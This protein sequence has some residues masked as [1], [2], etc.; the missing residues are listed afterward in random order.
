MH[1]LI[2]FLITDCNA[3]HS[4]PQKELFQEL[5]NRNI[6]KLYD[7]YQFRGANFRCDYWNASDYAQYI[8]GFLNRWNTV[9][10]KPVVLFYSKTTDSLRMWL[11]STDTV[12][13]AQRSISNDSLA[14]LEYLLR[15]NIEVEHARGSTIVVHQSASVT[16]NAVAEITNVLLPVEFR[17]SLVGKG[18]LFIVPEQNIGQIPFWLLQPYGNASILADSMSYSQVPHVCDFQN[19]SADHDTLGQKV[20]MNFK[21]PLLVGNPQY[22]QSLG[23]KDLPGA[24]KEVEM[25]AQM[26]DT[27]YLTA[28]QANVSI[29]KRLIKGADLIYFA[30]HAHCDMENVLNGSYIAFAPSSVSADGKLTLYEV[31]RMMLPGKLAVLSACE[32]GYGK[33]MEGGFVGLGRAFFKAG[34][35]YTVMSLWSVNDEATYYL[36]SRFMQYVLEPHEYNPAEPLRKAILDTRK[37]YPNAS[38][39]AAFQLFGFTL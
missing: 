11:F 16:H 25:V 34:V 36:M 4:V 35:D 37:Q 2:F 33:V 30:T 23:L 38:D 29:I 31:Q 28:E 12:L 7:V 26:L 6:Q 39:W 1:I 21:N 5:F 27:G 17:P 10:K 8:F 13:F 19:Y 15:Q 24:Q 9:S 14:K 32:T 22:A 3:Q 18:H 20:A